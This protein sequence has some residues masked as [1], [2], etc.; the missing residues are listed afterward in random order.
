ME[1][2]LYGAN[3]I[4]AYLELPITLVGA[5]VIDGDGNVG[6]LTGE[7][8]PWFKD[9]YRVAVDYGRGDVKMK[10]A[11]A[12][13]GRWSETPI[14]EEFSKEDLRQIPSRRPSGDPNKRVENLLE[15]M[16]NFNSFSDPRR[17]KISELITRL[18]TPTKN[19]SYLDSMRRSSDAL[20]S[21]EI[22]E[23]EASMPAPMSPADNA[24]MSPAGDLKKT[25]A[26]L[27]GQEIITTPSGGTYEKGGLLSTDGKLDKRAGDR[28]RKRN[29][30]IGAQERMVNLAVQKLVTAVKGERKAGREVSTDLMNTALGNLDNPLTRPQRNEVEALRAEAKEAKPKQ[31]EAIEK[32]ANELEAAY[33]AKNREA[34]KVR[35][36]QALAQLPEDVAE[37]ISEMTQHIT[38]LSSALKA[39][40]IVQTGTRGDDR[41][42]PWHLPASLLRNLRQPEVEGF[43]SQKRKNNQRRAKP[44]APKYRGPQR[45]Q[46]HRPSGGARRYPP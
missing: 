8:S 42:E 17:Q 36:A 5:E 30:K 24:F 2:L 6:N 46:A 35:Q 9:F 39:S 34:F 31:R 4:P 19:G 11:A 15:K 10:D 45:R 13:K 23:I 12:I 29:M 44:P 26:K 1:R 37:A 3:T 7:V 25:V 40:G 27:T 16:A 32:E 18:T 33:M 14:S 38:A 22:S 28:W 43:S 21:E 20:S 41:R